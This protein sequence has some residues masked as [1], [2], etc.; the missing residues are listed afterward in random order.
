MSADSTFNM[1]AYYHTEHGLIRMCDRTINGAR[2][3]PDVWER[4]YRLSEK[5]GRDR[6]GYCAAWMRFKGL[7]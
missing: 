4:A 2:I 3:P 7:I 1:L 6:F 5:Y